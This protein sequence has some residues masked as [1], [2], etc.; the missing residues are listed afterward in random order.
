[1]K[2]IHPRDQENEQSL[3]QKYN[4]IRFLDDD[5]NQNSM[6][7][8]ENLEFKGTTRRNKKYCVVGQPIDW[9]DWDNM[10]LLISRD[11]N[12]DFMA[13]AKGFEQEPD[14]GVNFFHP[15]INDDSEDT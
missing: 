5:D 7:A 8:P 13:I 1:M 9:R 3:L 11:I 6:I 14:L 15:S 4:N 10:Y 2:T 12:Y